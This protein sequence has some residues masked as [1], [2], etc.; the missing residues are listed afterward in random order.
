MG[1]FYGCLMFS[2]AIQK[3]F[4]GIYSALK[5][6]FDEF[7]GEKVVS[8]SYFSAILGPPPPMCFYLQGSEMVCFHIILI[9]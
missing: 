9:F 6:S 8:P 3:L 2:A 7:V 4:C 5:C 1:C